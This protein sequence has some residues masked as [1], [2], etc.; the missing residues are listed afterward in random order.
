MMPLT[1]SMPSRSG[2]YKA[3]NDSIY[4][5]EEFLSQ[6]DPLEIIASISKRIAVFNIQDHI[7]SE[8]ML[9]QPLIEYLMSLALAKPKPENPKK[10]EEGVIDSLLEHWK[11]L[12]KRFTAYFG[13]EYVAAGGGTPAEIRFKLI[14]DYFGVR[15]KAYQIHVEKTFTELFR[16][17]RS[18]II[19]KLGFSP[20][21][22]SKF[23]RFAE[24]EITVALQNELDALHSL[25]ELHSR[26]SKRIRNQDVE[27]KSKENIMNHF[28]KQDPDLRS[29]KGK[30]S[31]LS[32]LRIYDR[33]E[34]KAQND[35]QKRI[36]DAIS[37]SFEE[38]SIFLKPDKWR[39]WPINDTI[40]SERPIIK[41]EEKYYL[42]HF[43]M[44]ANSRIDIMESLLEKH[45]PEYFQNVYRPARD[46]YVEDTAVNLIQN[47]IPDSSVYSNLYYRV[48]EDG[49]AKRVELDALVLYDDC[50]LLIEAKAG[51]L[52]LPA[53]RGAIRGLK[54]K[55][56]E[57]LK[58]GHGQACRALN[59]IDSSKKA[60]FFDE[61]GNLVVSVNGAR[62]NHEYLILVTLEPLFVL[63]SHLSSA[64]SLGL[65]SGNKWPWAVYINDLRILADIIDSPSVF[66]HYLN[67]RIELNSKS[68]IETHDELDY[69]MYYLHTGLYFS[70]GDLEQADKIVIVPHT[71]ELDE[72]YF[73]IWKKGAAKT[74]PSMKMNTLFETLIRRLETEMPDHFTSAC[75]HLLNC[76]ENTRSEISKQIKK[77]EQRHSAENRPASVAFRINGTGLLLACM[78]DI[79]HREEF[80]AKWA[81]RWLEEMHVTQVTVLLWKPTIQNGSI[82]L[83]MF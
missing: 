62:F 47:L 7:E 24:T 61:D 63:T 31:Q 2:L 72:Y 51:M 75:F 73:D 53:R 66:L 59:Y 43:E 54:S 23:I 19:D 32:E 30:V 13:S 37:C 12:V 20:E 4:D 8:D 27:G 9:W 17:H 36:L 44:L 79:N 69:F 58:K 78:E 39:A 74:K 3:V 52:P 77:C 81:R 15:K 35:V 49:K 67:R 5:I 34:I 55:V 65:L 70:E 21:D 14:L 41:T 42:P 48:E 28:L 76:D 26:F 80:A 64:K 45:S 60:D 56:K 38:N 25:S 46:R 57:I 82:K 40:I 68:A 71:V 18:H 83:F 16:P 33:F 29:R 10:L 22:F 50:L 1:N 11:K 6:H